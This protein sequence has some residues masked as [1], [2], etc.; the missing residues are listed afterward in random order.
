MQFNEHFERYEREISLARTNFSRKILELSKEKDPRNLMIFWLNFSSLGIAMTEFVED[1]IRRAGQK[2]KDLGYE[3]LGVKLIK[4]ATHERNHHLMMIADTHKL[5]EIWNQEYAPPALQAN[6]LMSRKPM[7]STLAYQKLHEDCIKS[8]NPF[9]QIAIEYE[10]ENLSIVHGPGILKNS[11]ESLGKD[12]QSCLTFVFDHVEIDQ[13]H[14]VYNREAMCE[15]LDEFPTAVN[16]LVAIG[17]KAL[18]IYGSFLN[19]CLIHSEVFST[20]AVTA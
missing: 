14:T 13:A 7:A 3:H 9:G 5:T 1:W 10:I 11:T 4:H 16:D 6:Q 15:F 17:S 18:D 2:T 12:I 8:E 19:D 20:A